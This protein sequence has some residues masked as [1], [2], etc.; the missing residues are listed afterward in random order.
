[1]TCA[2]CSQET[3]RVHW[4]GAFTNGHMTDDLSGSWHLLCKRCHPKSEKFHRFQ[5]SQ[6]CA[7]GTYRT[8]P[9][10]RVT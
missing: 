9:L 8:L 2:R 1:M 6:M 10:A 7:H 3:L 5:G 4:H